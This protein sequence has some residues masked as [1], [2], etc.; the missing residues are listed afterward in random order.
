MAQRV[1][2]MR[3]GRVSARALAAVLR[4][5]Y[6]ARLDAAPELL[7]DLRAVCRQLR[8]DPAVD[9]ELSDAAALNGQA[10]PVAL[11]SAAQITAHEAA[12][13]TWHGAS[14]R[15][16]ALPGRGRT[17][18]RLAV[19]GLRAGE[20]GPAVAIAATRRGLLP[21]AASVPTPQPRGA[22]ACA[23]VH[24]VFL[25]GQ[26]EYFH[27]LLL[28]GSTAPLPPAAAAAAAVTTTGMA[29]ATATARGACAPLSVVQVGDI[30]PASLAAIVE[31]VY[32]GTVIGLAPPLVF[33]LV[34]DADALLPAAARA[35]RDGDRA[36]HGRVERV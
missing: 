15:A 25:C 36:V 8:L 23:A 3:N 16:R 35:V 13:A 27:A 33:E 21:V 1:V 14:A 10:A 19:R 26:S 6:T 30:S 17:R 5:M 28:G 7:P 24:V 12:F 18:A 22:R 2:A 11:G 34:R 4:W 32:S 29:T 31:F 20:R 9:A